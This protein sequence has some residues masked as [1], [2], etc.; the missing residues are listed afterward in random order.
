MPRKSVGP[1]SRLAVGGSSPTSL[2]RVASSFGFQARLP[3]PRATFPRP[4]GR[5][6]TAMAS[7][8]SLWHCRWRSLTAHPSAPMGHGVR[9]VRR[10][11]S[12]GVGG[13]GRVRQSRRLTTRKLHFASSGPA[14]EG[15]N[16]ATLTTIVTNDSLRAITL[17]DVGLKIAGRARTE[18]IVSTAEALRGPKPPVTLRESEAAEWVFDASTLWDV[19]GA[20]RP[21]VQMAALDSRGV[22]YTQWYSRQRVK[23]IPMLLEER[24]RR[25]RQEREV[26][27]VLKQMKASSRTREKERK[28]TEGDATIG[29]EARDDG[30][31]DAR[32][33]RC[34]MIDA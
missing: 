11:D 29:S 31:T 24:R 22:E 9:D 14:V 6:T 33:H 20:K 2:R 3:R 16:L 13:V 30:R 19:L 26:T 32:R 18:V 28:P 23:R 5:L 21:I 8:R 4:R 17:K 12:G 10:G 7:V 25:R 27:A 15:P 34:Q 1:P